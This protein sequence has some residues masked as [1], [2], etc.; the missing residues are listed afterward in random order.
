M[1]TI[2]YLNFLSYRPYWIKIVFW[3]YHRHFWAVLFASHLWDTK[4]LV[5]SSMMKRKWKVR[6][7]WVRAL[8]LLQIHHIYIKQSYLICLYFSQSSTCQKRNL[9]CHGYSLLSYCFLTESKA[10]DLCRWG[11]Y[12]KTAVPTRQCCLADYSCQRGQLLERSNTYILTPQD[13][14]NG[15]WMGN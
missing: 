5:W 6:Y 3:R 15:I 1:Q 14:L 10:W 11:W 2:F 8:C 12:F 9:D 7:I 4:Y 13:C